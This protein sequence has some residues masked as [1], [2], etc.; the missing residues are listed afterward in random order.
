MGSSRGGELALQLASIYKAIGAVVAYVPANVRYPSCCGNTIVPYA[1]TWTGR[2]LAFLPLR[3]SQNFRAIEEATIKVEYIQ[4]PVLL[5]SGEDDHVWRSWA[6]AD[7]IV[8][9]LK[10]HHFAFEVEHLKYPHAGHAAGLPEIIPVWRGRRTQPVSGRVID[11][12]GSAQGN[13]MS[14]IDSMPKVIDFL[15]RMGAGN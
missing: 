15:K 5:V 4:G 10:H 12:G 7:E 2:P 14:T 6:M 11:F 9:R 13:A 1:W 3:M 8:S